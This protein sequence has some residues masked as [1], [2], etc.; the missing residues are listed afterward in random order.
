[1]VFLGSITKI[2]SAKA[3]QSLS[4]DVL[5][6]SRYELSAACYIEAYTDDN[7]LHFSNECPR[8]IN[9]TLTGDLEFTLKWFHEIAHAFVLYYVLYYLDFSPCSS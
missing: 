9:D 1:M 4:V 3:Q 2:L 7:W 5:V 8:Q 6:D